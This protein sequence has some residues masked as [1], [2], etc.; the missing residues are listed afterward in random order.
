MVDIHL[1]LASVWFLLLGLI[2]MFYVVT[3][4]F[5]LGVG[6]L[7]LFERDND[8]RT[9]MM[10]GLKGVWD[11]N[12]TWLIL[13]GG[14][15]FGA[16]PAVYALVLQALYIPITAILFGLILRGVAFEFRAHARSKRVWNLAFG[17]GSLLATLAQGYALGGVIGGLPVA[18]DQFTGTVWSWLSPFSTMVAVGVAAGYALLGGTYLIIKT[19]G[20]L[21]SISR[22][23]SRWASW[24]MLSAAAVVPIAIPL[25]HGYITQRWFRLPDVLYLVPVPVIALGAF[26]MLM[27]SLRRGYEISPFVWSLVI[28]VVSFVGLATSLYPY[29]LPPAL[30]LAATASS[31]VTLVFM[32]VGIGMLIP[33]M[34]V[35]NGYQYLVF[36]GK[37]V[38]DEDENYA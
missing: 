38:R 2:L 30:T 10:A 5:D 35:Y 24:I 21:Q 6:I 31:S 16:F 12:E 36:R 33:V 26:V 18:D 19:Q 9:Q 28:F 11:A 22:K 23:R 34:L 14:A 20:K 3:D 15:L 7:S 27:Q 17:G 1:F 32:L 25:L 4:G 8:R 13:F 29:L 37:L